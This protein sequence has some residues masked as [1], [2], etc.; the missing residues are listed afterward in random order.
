VYI[1]ESGPGDQ[2]TRGCV[3]FIHGFPFD[4]SMWEPQLDALPE[5]WRGLAPDL[6]GFGRSP[7][8]G[9]PSKASAGRR[10]GSGI[11]RDDEP[12]LSMGRLARE[13][14]D[15]IDGECNG[16]AVVCGLSMGG[17]VS[18]ELL[19]HQAERIRGLILVDT[20]AEADSDEARENRLLM[21]QTARDSGSGPI[22]TSMI[23]DLLAGSTRQAKPDI[24]DRVRSMILAVPAVTVVGALAGMAA[25][26]DSTGDLARIGVPTLVVV[27]EEDAITP[28][29]GARRMAE[30]I[31]GAA[32][33]VIPDAG[34]LSN[35]ENPDAFNRAMG[36]FLDSL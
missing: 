29:D 6:P 4:S 26:H 13:I 20:R 28:P 33:E 34:H 1:R 11:A 19:R 15:L 32:L 18:F 23:P 8:N 10:Q 14:A 31:P 3:V 5:G 2:T 12:V 24:V 36:T 22:A 30:A 35:L 21:A 27:G 25:R 16:T 9:Q 17:Y 7:L